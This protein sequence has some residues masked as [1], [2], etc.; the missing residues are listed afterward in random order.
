MNEYKTGLLFWDINKNKRKQDESEQMYL[1]EVNKKSEFWKRYIHRLDLY[2]P[3][4]DF[5][6]NKDT[7][8]GE[9]ISQSD[10]KYFS[11]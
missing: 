9:F 8:F 3:D 1:Y 4:N 5:Y 10:I 6:R 7:K 2:N 11:K